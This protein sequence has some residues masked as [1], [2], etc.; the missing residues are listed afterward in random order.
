MDVGCKRSGCKD[1]GEAIAQHLGMQLLYAT[2]FVEFPAPHMRE[3]KAAGGGV[4]GN[5][6]VTWLDVEE[7]WAFQHA[8]EPYDWRHRGG[9]LGEPRAG[10]RVA[11]GAELRVPAGAIR[12]AATTLRCYSLHL[13][14]FC[15]VIGR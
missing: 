15:G 14:N 7:A 12:T 13:E 8:W 9:M 11:V 3:A 1:V 5:A 2:E 10:A 4:H 6:I